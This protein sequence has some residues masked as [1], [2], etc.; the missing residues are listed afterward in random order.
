MP[1]ITA[2]YPSLSLMAQL[3]DKI[4]NGKNVGYCSSSEEEEDHGPQFVSGEDERQVAVMRGI[5]NTGPKGVLEDW[6]SFHNEQKQQQKAKFQEMI[7]EAKRGMLSG[8]EEG[9][10]E[11]LQRIREERLQQ[12]K[13][14]VA[15][16][17]KVTEMET[18]EQ[19]LS[20][21]EKCRN[22][23]LLI[24]IYEEA[25]DGCV[26]MNSVLC[27]VAAKYPQVKLARVKS[28]VLKTSATFSSN[29]LPTLQVYY[30]DALVGNFVRIT[31]HL[32]E[33]FTTSQ[34]VAFLYEHDI[35]LALN[36][37]SDE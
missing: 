22:A 34:V 10:D 1:R 3:D 27:S 12:L 37:R 18:K 26:T 29:A 32:G 16:K 23:L 11:E 13:D 21:I 19:F 35:D 7:A 2:N 36:T 15:S 28:S 20:A 33:D 9:V 31:D 25:V 17:G 6:R 5:R 4:L 24:H 14:R 8:N 30:N